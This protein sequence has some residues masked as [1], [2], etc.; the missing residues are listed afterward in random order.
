M[1]RASC[2]RLDCITGYFRGRCLSYCTLWAASLRLVREVLPKVPT[3][4]STINYQ[5]FLPLKLLISGLSIKGNDSFHSPY[6]KRH[7]APDFL[8]NDSFSSKSATEPQC[9]ILGTY[10]HYPRVA[11]CQR[12]I[13][14]RRHNM[15]SASHGQ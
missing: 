15:H 5:H 14:L 9:Q 8:L 2:S 10:L 7:C 12:I 1:R 11:L 6:T 13:T 4:H 3:E